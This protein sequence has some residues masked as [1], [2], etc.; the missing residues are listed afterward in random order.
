[1][2]QCVTWQSLAQTSPASLVAYST[3]RQLIHLLKR[4]CHSIADCCAK[5]EKKQSSLPFVWFRAH[6]HISAKLEWCVLDVSHR[7]FRTCTYAVRDATNNL[8][9][10]NDSQT[11]VTWPRCVSSD[12]SLQYGFSHFYNSISCRQNVRTPWLLVT[13]ENINISVSNTNAHRNKYEIHLR[14]WYKRFIH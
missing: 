12:Y 13:S 3:Q 10:S 7:S 9:N 14:D 11:G 8:I 5:Y 4:I 1:M 6:I 2:T